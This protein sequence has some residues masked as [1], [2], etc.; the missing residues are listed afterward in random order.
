MIPRYKWDDEEQDWVED[1][2]PESD[3][4]EEDE[5]SDDDASEN[6]AEQQNDQHSTK[7]RKIDNHS[8]SND[9]KVIDPK[10][11]K[12]KRTKKAPNTWIY[13]TGLPANITVEEIKAH[14]S[15]VGLIA[16]NPADQ[17][18]RIKIYRDEFG[19]CKGDASL[20][21]NASTSVALAIDILSG[22]YI[23]PNAMVTVTAANFVE[24][25]SVAAVVTGDKEKSEES[26]PPRARPVIT[27][28]QRKVAQSAMKQALA[29]N[30]DDD[31]GISKSKALRIIVIEGMF[32]P[33]D[34][35]T[36][37]S[38]S[39]ALE[40]DIASECSKYG[41]IDK[42][43]VFSQNPLG[44]VVIKYK[45]SFA[46]QECIR[47]MDGR[48]FAGRRLT[49]HYWDGVTNYSSTNNPATATEDEDKARL[50]DFGDWLENEQDNLPSEL[51]LRV[52]GE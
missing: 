11:K 9:S 10:K 1:S 28:A 43:T 5:N 33:E 23:R 29:W 34:F 27:A 20:C 3:G 21:Y 50:D 30:E 22:G 26:K 6:E 31:L 45:T 19:Q 49:A 46:A 35:V 44:I 24:N 42:I 16:I 2:E 38:F 7:R 17:L 15:K 12:K 51:R 32:S 39:D 18:P 40:Q 8:N 52:E 13:I 14:F 25:K 47:V 4:D 36:D 41:E 48:Y 37:P